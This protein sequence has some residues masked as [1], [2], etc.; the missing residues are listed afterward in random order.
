MTR[1]ALAP[2]AT[3]GI[4]GGGQLGRMLAVAAARLGYKTCIFEPGADCPA[5][6]VA[7]YHFKAGFDD[8]E[9]LARFGAACDAVTFEFEN[10]RTD[11]LALIGD[12]APVRPGRRALKA[13]QDRLLE[14][15][16]LSDL[17][18]ATAP[19]AAVDDPEAL[20]EAMAEIGTPGLLKTRR[21]G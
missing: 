3:I 5:S 13:S 2:G 14:K 4:L 19:F 7:N 10:I 1:E 21:V 18:L 6:H 9:A 12:A 16:F 15:A 20:A 17:G 11:T 8:A